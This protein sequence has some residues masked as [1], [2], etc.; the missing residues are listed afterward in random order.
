MTEF[1]RTPWSDTSTR[2]DAH[3]RPAFPEIPGKGGR[4]PYV[5]D[6][7]P[8]DDRGTFLSDIAFLFRFAF[9]MSSA[10]GDTKGC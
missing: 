1:N 2:F 8:K 6:V 5:H 9:G 3:F 4:G 10:Y 7:R